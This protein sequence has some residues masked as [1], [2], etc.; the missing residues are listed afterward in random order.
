MLSY[1]E[2]MPLSQSETLFLLPGRCLEPPVIHPGIYSA[3][4]KDK[5]R[6]QTLIA[7]L[8][9]CKLL[10]V[11][12]TQ[13]PGCSHMLLTFSQHPPGFF[14]SSLF[15]PSVQNGLRLH[16]GEDVHGTLSAGVCIEGR[17][18]QGIR[19]RGANYWALDLT[20]LSINPHPAS[21]FCFQPFLPVKESSPP[22]QQP[23]KPHFFFFTRGNSLGSP[24]Y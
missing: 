23:R 11:F 17:Y 10:P 6:K 19:A 18:G 21:C 14:G 1:A 12:L 9:T 16:F 2:P 5:D 8:L 24:D 4:F 7:P 22:T 20:R 15:P 3:A 13:S